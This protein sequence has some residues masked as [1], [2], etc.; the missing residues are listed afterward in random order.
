MSPDARFS[1]SLL[2]A[3]LS[4]VAGVAAGLSSVAGVAAGLSSV[5]G[6]AAG[7]SSVTGVAAGL[8]SVTGLSSVAGLSLPLIS[9]PILEIRFVHC[10]SPLDSKLLFRS[11]LLS[12]TLTTLF[13]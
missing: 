5:T 6:V 12:L 13:W 8:S 9:Q 3:G 1:T 11:L 7:L 10:G 4:S 2:A